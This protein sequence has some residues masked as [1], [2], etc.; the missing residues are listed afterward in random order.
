MANEFLKLSF[1]TVSMNRCHHLKKTLVQNIVD[2]ISYPKIEFV[3]LDYNSTD[4]LNQWIAGELHEYI[5]SGVLVYFRTFDPKSFHRSHSRNLSFKLASG[6]ILCNIDADNYTGPNFASYI[7]DEFNGNRNIFLTPIDF[8]KIE[9]NHF[10][11]PDTLGRV[12]FTKE[13]FHSVRGYTET[14]STHG[15]QD[16][17]FANRLE[18]FGCKRVIIKNTRFLQAESHDDLER[19]KNEYINSNL[20]KI[21]CSPL[22]YFSSCIIFLYT[23][24][25]FEKGILIDNSIKGSRNYLASFIRSRYK[26]EFSLKEK[27]WIKGTWH[28]DKRGNITFVFRNKK[29]TLNV[30]EGLRTQ[31]KHNRTDDMFQHIIDPSIINQLIIFNTQYTNRNTM[32]D[33]WRRKTVVTNGGA[34]GVGK[35]FKNFDFEHAVNV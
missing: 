27:A 21:I 7:N 4:G 34:Y 1:C 13:A 5:D 2:N 30:V 22:T 20:Y 18:L 19:F 10:P 6:D 16:Y 14:M 29:D 23:N 26:Y 9:H 28:K 11:L 3:V 35:V 8:H 24:S 33:N 31:W 12:C 25:T 17:D 32:L 15:F